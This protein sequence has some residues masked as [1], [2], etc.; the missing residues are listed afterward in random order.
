[1]S[2][3]K[4]FPIHRYVGIVQNI[5]CFNR[6]FTIGILS[7]PTEG[8]SFDTLNCSKLKL[9]HKSKSTSTK[10]LIVINSTL[11]YI[12]SISLFDNLNQ[13]QFL[14]VYFPVLKLFSL[15]CCT[16]VPEPIAGIFMKC[17]IL[18]YLSFIYSVQARTL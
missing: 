15:C 12:R 10:S 9:R 16:C 14:G 17:D 1:M 18:E 4:N 11:T 2:V 13:N 6:K 3:L 7:Y 8:L 5:S